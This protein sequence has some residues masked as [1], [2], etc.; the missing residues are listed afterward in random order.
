[1]ILCWFID[2][3]HDFLASRSLESSKVMLDLEVRRRER[4]PCSFRAHG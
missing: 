3:G 4:G 2:V 1:V